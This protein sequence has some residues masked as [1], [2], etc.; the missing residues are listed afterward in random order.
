MAFLFVSLN[1]TNGVRK[2]KKTDK[3]FCKKVDEC[4]IIEHSST[5]VGVSFDVRQN[6]MNRLAAKSAAATTI[7]SSGKTIPVVKALG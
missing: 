2:K 5:F 3:N 1:Y 6:Q 7:A 4:S